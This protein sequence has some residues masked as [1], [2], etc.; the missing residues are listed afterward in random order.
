[1]FRDLQDRVDVPLHLTIVGDGP[2]LGAVQR[3][4]ARRGLGPSVTLTGRVAPSAVLDLLTASDL[5]VAPSI[6]ES[7]GL[8]AL[9]ARAVGLPVVGYA[10]SGLTDFIRTGVEGHLADSDAD[11]VSALRR[12]V[13]DETL[14][15]RTAEH[16]RTVRTEMT[17]T[18]SLDRHDRVYTEATTRAVSSSESDAE[19]APTDEVRA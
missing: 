17:W 16:N 5:Y 10:V 4:L 2:L 11:L 8:A 13:T 6:R 14:R 18:N 9:E 3:Q 12:L 19:G 15:W 7:F 1:M